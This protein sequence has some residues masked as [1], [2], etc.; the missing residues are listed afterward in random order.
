MFAL[1]CK[2]DLEGIVAKDKFGPYLQNSAQWFRIRKWKYSQWASREKFFEREAALLRD[3][4]EKGAALGLDAEMTRGFFRGQIEAAK[5]IQRADF[6][7][8]QTD[9][10][11]PEGEPPDLAGVLRPRID[12]LNRDLLAELASV[13]AELLKRDGTA[14]LRGRAGD[15]LVG[16]GIDDGV[17]ETAIGPLTNPGR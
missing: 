6:G 17:R 7:H 10:R 12:G 4:A 14:R 9:G 5:A 1:A 3:V 8:W 16:S 15:L 13:K 2:R 11:G